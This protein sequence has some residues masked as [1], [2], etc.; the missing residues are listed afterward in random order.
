[1]DLGSHAAFIW[2]SYLVVAVTIAFLIAWLIADGK[3]QAAELNSLERRG[4]KRRASG[5]AE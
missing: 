4:I 2:I 5:A 1:M 3:K